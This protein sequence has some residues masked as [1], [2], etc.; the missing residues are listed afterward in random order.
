M[1]GGR[2]IDRRSS[3]LQASDTGVISERANRRSAR[4]VHM[5]PLAA[6]ARVTRGAIRRG[7]ASGRPVRAHEVGASMRRRLGERGHT[8]VSQRDRAGER[9]VARRTHVVVRQVRARAMRVTRDAPLWYG[10]RDVHPLIWIGERVARFAR[11]VLHLG[12]MHRM[13]EHEQAGSGANGRRPLNA[14]LHRSV[15]TRT[16]ECDGG[17]RAGGVPRR[18][19]R[20]TARTH[21]EEASV[22]R[23]RKSGASP[24]LPPQCGGH[25]EQ[26]KHPR[27]SA[28][29]A[30]PTMPGSRPSIHSTRIEPRRCVQSGPAA[31]FVSVC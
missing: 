9:P 2:W 24:C 8:G 28:H 14:R 22:G 15:M 27:E 25:H 23:M 6:L 19:P 18:D 1:V 17:K 3:H 20:V 5:A 12:Q 13:R 26:C 30:L 4:A 11:D 7:S 21:K 16:A 29:G 10:V 31:P